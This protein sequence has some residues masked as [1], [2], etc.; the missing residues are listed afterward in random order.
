MIM[1][2]IH[3]Q[4]AITTAAAIDDNSDPDDR[5]EHV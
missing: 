2:E 3:N 4:H 1:M 5:C